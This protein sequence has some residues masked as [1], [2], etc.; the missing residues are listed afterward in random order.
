MRAIYNTTCD[1]IDGPG[2][3]TPGTVR[4]A[5]VPCR[6]IIE[7]IIIPLN[8]FVDQRTHYMTTDELDVHGGVITPDGAQKWRIAG[9]RADRIAIQSGAAAGYTA[10]WEELVTP[11]SG[12]PYLRVHLRDSV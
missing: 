6:L 5:N 7:T 12:T 3:A 4:H 9:L 1:I 10:L 2:T 8:L 11:S